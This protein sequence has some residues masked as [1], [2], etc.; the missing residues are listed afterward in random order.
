MRYQATAKKLDGYRRQ[1]AALRAKMR[2]A[3]VAAEPEEVQDYAFTTPHGSTKLSD[4]FGEKR[5]LIM[6]HNM[7]ASCPYCTL[8]A[9]GFNGIYHHLADRAAFAV[10]SPDPPAA[11][12]KFAAKRGWR[13]PMVSHQGT[14]FAAD[15]G[16]QSKDGGCLPGVSVFRKQRARILRVSDTGFSPGDDFCAMWHILDLLPEGAADWGPKL[17]YA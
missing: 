2:K 14:S 15:M 1:I 12:N 7:G 3:Q 9:D 13:F 8:W 10:S 6:I 16:Y 17:A 5:E 4:L 11:Q